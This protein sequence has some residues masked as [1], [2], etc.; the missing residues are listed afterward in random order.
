MTPSDSL[1]IQFWPVDEETFNE[2]VICGLVKQD[3]FCQPFNCDDE[4]VLQFQNTNALALR[5]LSG[6]EMA[7]ATLFDQGFISDL[8]DFT[9]S[10]PGSGFWAWDAAYGGSA[11]TV[12]SLN[13]TSQRLVK[14]MTITE[15][16]TYRVTVSYALTGQNMTL[17]FYSGSTLIDSLL[18][19]DNSGTEASHEIEFVATT[20]E[21]EIYF[22]VTDMAGGSATFYITDILFEEQTDDG[23]VLEEIELTQVATGIWEVD[24]V[25][26]E[27]LSPALCN[28]KI[29][30]EVGEGFQNGDF[31]TLAGWE[32]LPSMGVIGSGSVAWSIVANQARAVFGF[33]Q[34]SQVLRQAVTFAPDTYTFYMNFNV[35]NTAAGNV[36]LYFVLWDGGSNY[37]WIVNGAGAAGENPAFVG[38][39]SYAVGSHAIAVQFTT[40]RE[41]RYIAFEAAASVG[42]STVDVNYI[43]ISPEPFTEL[44]K[45]D[46]IDLK[47]DHECTK[48]ISYSNSSDFDGI[49]YQSASPA[50][51]FNLRVP[52]VF[53]E[54]NNPQEQEDLELSNGVIVTIRSSIQEKRLLELG[55]MP[56]HMHRKVQKILMHE[57]IQIDDTYWK[58]RDSYDANAIHKYNLK[59]AQVWLTKYNSVEK[60]TI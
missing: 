21:T 50:P 43:H 6:E 11:K 18:V 41:Y 42:V 59:K 25:P 19:T 14:S 51:T 2:K 31:N 55:Y 15:G 52:A 8:G 3:C 9:S 44:Y 36:S 60:N 26:N 53:Y 33:A 27:L 54:E 49:A 46:C 1:P 47:E 5:I 16:T 37:L 40:T 4:I 35:A 28:Q 48:L 58:K 22:T 24:F 17:K 34:D 32:N 57:T 30:L 20:D 29:A 56:N 7:F 23:T 39:Q 38:P 12:Q 10:S 13:H 45:S